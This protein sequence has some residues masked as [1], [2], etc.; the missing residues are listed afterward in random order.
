MN[1]T[2]NEEQMRAVVTKAIL[3]GLG[4]EQKTLI[5][6][7]AV[8]HLMGAPEKSG[9]SYKQDN[10]NRLQIAFDNAAERALEQIAREEMAKPENVEKLRALVGPC[11]EQALTNSTSYAAI[12]RAVGSAIAAAFDKAE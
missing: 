11:L 6:Q 3:E 8:E 2:L 9:Y 10:R 1:L 4:D 5:L 12:K 7:Q